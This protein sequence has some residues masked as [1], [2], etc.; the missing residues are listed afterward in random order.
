MKVSCLCVT[1]GMFVPNAVEQFEKQTYPQ[2]ELVVVYQDPLSAMDIARLKRVDARL[3]KAKSSLNL[4]QLRNLALEAARGEFVLQW[5]DD[6]LFCPTRIQTMLGGLREAN[7]DA[8]VLQRWYI[9]DVQARIMYLSSART[10]EGSALVRT[11]L[12]R[13]IGFQSLP[14]GEDSQFFADFE[15]SGGKLAKLDL[16]TLYVYRIHG[17]N[18]WDRK[19]FD[20]LVSHA[21]LVSSN[22]RE[23]VLW[24]AL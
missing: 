22:R 8:A 1:R 15:K 16:P 11:S 13:S 21:E 9:D 20:A 23:A 14:R 19:H 12:A 2:R 10:W 3:V 5:D 18:T 17:G 4:G 24:S 6:D 7:A